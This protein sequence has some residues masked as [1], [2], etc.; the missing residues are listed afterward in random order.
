[1]TIRIKTPE[2]ALFYA[3][4]AVL[5][6]IL[7]T[8]TVS[9]ARADEGAIRLESWEIVNEFPEGFRIKA[10]AN[11]DNEISSIAVRLRIGRQTH[12]AYDYLCKSGG[13]VEPADWICDE[14]ATGKLVDGELF[15]RTN[16]RA[17]YIPPGTILTYNL[18]IEDSEGNFFKTDPQEFLYHDT[19]FE[20]KEVSEGPITVSYHGPVET[21]A[22]II[23]DAMVQTLGHMGP[24]LGADV[25]E[26]IRVTM[27][28]NIKEMLDALPPGSAT[29]GR[30]LVTEGQAFSEMGTL[31]TL[32]SGQLAEGTASHE[33]THIL[34]HR[35]SQ[36]TSCVPSWLNEG[37]AEYGNIVPG[38]SYDIALDFAVE[39]DRLMPFT[40]M[41][42]MPGDPEAAIIFY[43]QSRSMVRIL[44]QEFGTEKM[45][46]LMQ[47]L[48]TGRRPD[49]VI[50][51]VYGI[52][53]SQ[54]DDLWRQAIGAEPLERRVT[55][56]SLPTAIPRR[57]ILPYSLTPQAGVEVI[58]DKSE[59]TPTAETAAGSSQE[60][61]P[62]PAAGVA[63]EDQPTSDPTGESQPS[64]DAGSDT[65]PTPEPAAES[66]QEPQA[67]PGGGCTV[68]LH[69]AGSTLDLTGAGLLL[70]MVALGLRRK[71]GPGS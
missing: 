64:S 27:F 54:L 23:L 51:S 50:Q 37:L 33:M 6:A 28:N 7:L 18:E 12:G 45:R 26:P 47:R 70:G 4:F 20:W 63:P 68:A 71:R 31:L 49:R 1:M 2:S 56:R 3:L 42:V 52:S 36:C 35:A 59:D 30:E 17:R 44:I 60:D 25:D 29:V 67:A 69:S 10:K 5:V 38:Y 14:F 41:T 39:T 43:G 61:G 16:S 66:E 46:E 58:G 19:R 57:T 15:W 22:N 62:T 24:L 13:E 34:V 8:V 21:R 65:A 53:L 40:S 55:A 32:G 48:E 11:G 9:P